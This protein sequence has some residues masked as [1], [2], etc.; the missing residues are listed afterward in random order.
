LE[1]TIEKEG[2]NLS[3]EEFT[4][5]SGAKWA[6]GLSFLDE[7]IRKKVLEKTAKLHRK[8]RLPPE[9]LWQGIHYRDKIPAFVPKGLVIRWINPT[10]G[11]GVFALRSF[12][13]GE[14]IG[15][16]GGVIRKRR[17]DD[18]KNA[19]CFEYPFSDE[20]DSPYVIDALDQGGLLRYL[21]HSETGNITAALATF[22]DLTHIIFIVKESIAPGEQL[23]YDYGPNYWKK[24]PS[25]QSL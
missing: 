8:G 22:D 9:Q 17:R 6:Q 7:K 23:C 14:F 24:R 25:P 12:R 19:Y 11:W 21:N 5:V 4:Q 3:L 13:R 16:Y 18:I 15:E 10:L 20:I 2:K 1:I